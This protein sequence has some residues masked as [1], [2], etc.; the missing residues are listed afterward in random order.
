MK[1]NYVPSDSNSDVTPVA[2]HSC[3]VTILFN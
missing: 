1:D 2:S 3:T